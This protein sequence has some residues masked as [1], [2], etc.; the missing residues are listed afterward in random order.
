[1]L[2]NDLDGSEEAWNEHHRSVRSLDRDVRVSAKGGRKDRLGDGEVVHGGPCR[3]CEFFADS[4][5]IRRIFFVDDG[6]FVCMTLKSHYREQ[7]ERIIFCTFGDRDEELY[8]GLV[9]SRFIFSQ[10]TIVR[11]STDGSRQPLYFPPPPP[12]T[13]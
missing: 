3:F 2:Q 8:K 7:V 12:G 4:G 10:V 11:H 6:A 9:V 1:M 13:R 5:S